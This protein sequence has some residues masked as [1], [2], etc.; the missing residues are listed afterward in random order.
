MCCQRNTDSHPSLSSEETQRHPIKMFLLKPH[1]VASVSPPT[2]T[3][4]PTC[5]QPVMSR[6]VGVTPA[7]SP[8]SMF[9]GRG[10]I[11]WLS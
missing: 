6:D 3:E 8:F 4:I 11:R 9:S 5:Q 1:Q 7:A 10:R 2:R